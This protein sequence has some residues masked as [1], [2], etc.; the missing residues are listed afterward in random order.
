MIMLKIEI[1][2]FVFLEE[3][4]KNEKRGIFRICFGHWNGYFYPFFSP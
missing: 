3:N 4:K 2:F 1:D